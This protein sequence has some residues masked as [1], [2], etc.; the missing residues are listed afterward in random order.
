MIGAPE[1][2]VRPLLAD[3]AIEKEHF[4][5]ENPRLL[6]AKYELDA[7][8]PVLRLARR[9]PAVGAGLLLPY[10]AVEVAHLMARWL[11]GSRRFR[12]VAEQ[13]FERHG[14]Q[15]VA[16][17]LPTALGGPPRE[18]RPVALA[19]TRLDP[20][21]VR[22]AAEQLGCSAQVEA[23]LAIDPL[24][25][26]P[27]S[28]PKVPAWLDLDALPPVLLRDG[29]H[30]LPRSAVESLC[31]MAAM[32]QLDEPYEGLRVVGEALDPGS[33]A[34]FGWALFAEWYLA[35]RPSR[36]A[37]MFDALA[38]FGDA[39]VADRLASMIPRWPGLGAA[40]RAKRGADVLAAMDDDAAVQHLGVLARRAKSGPLRAHAA[41][42]L[43]RAA[44]DR[45][46]LPEQLDDLLAPDLGLGETV[47]HRGVEHT[48][49]LGAALDVVLR[50]A[51][52][53]RTTLPRPRDD[54]EK[55]VVT[56]WNTRRRRA[57]SAVSDQVRR[58]E[59]AMVVQRSWTDQEFAAAICAH[60]LLGRLARRLVWSADDR[61]AVV[62][63]LG[64]LVGLD[65]AMVS[66]ASAVRLA[67][68]ATSDLTPWREWLGDQGIAQP[69]SQIERE[70]FDDDPSAHWNRTVSAAS[71]Y[72]LLRRG[73]HWGPTGR[74]ALRDRI[75]RPLGPA[76]TVVLAFTPGLS[77]VHDAAGE[78]DQTLE[79]L[80]LES[81][82]H[83][84]LAVFGDL[85]RV[86]R[87]ELVRD[88]R[89][90]T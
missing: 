18:S 25:L 19:L 12:P 16:L 53:E 26:V 64:D 76:G 8:A 43:D 50:T 47:H 67:H 13:W 10:R 9:K 59:E 87:S 48:V 36:D 1:A 34:S 73:W 44:F 79:W 72:T 81:P 4:H 74:G 63:A 31:R 45:G 20:A 3:W 37:W 89:L 29:A 41:Q 5:L 33:L 77:A 54:D 30:A 42:A 52:G 61:T 46:L 7:L 62:D 38:Y 24:D 68:P 22:R 90:L 58:L 40:A 69:F 39:S 49:E 14:A 23:L 35:E 32:S 80:N 27:S 21:V 56:A 15:G 70:V 85:P 83:G 86:T 66:S 65:G 71:L 28:V 82:Q 2:M 55:S 57:R 88:L 17:V 84:E 51:D 60:P 6:V 78:P 75:V 11:S